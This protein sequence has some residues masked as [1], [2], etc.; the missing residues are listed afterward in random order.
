MD[1]NESGQIEKIMDEA[2]E[3]IKGIIDV[4]TVIGEPIL[5]L[6]G[7][8]IIPITK[9]SVGFVAGGGEYSQDAPRKMCKKGYPFAG[10]S[11][12]GFN[13]TPVGFL[14]GK[15]ENLKLIT[16][17]NKNTFDNV[18]KIVADITDKISKK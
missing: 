8:T 16:V 9:V 2:L 6:D 12:G 4:N 15:K 13:V 10:G 18:V 3:K 7:L 11:G 17:E 14:I 5:T 1:R